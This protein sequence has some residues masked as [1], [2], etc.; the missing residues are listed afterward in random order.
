MARMGH[1]S[2]RPA[3]IYQQASQGR[4]KVIAQA[5]GEVLKTVRPT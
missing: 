1:V 3:L 2:P 4:D 5:L